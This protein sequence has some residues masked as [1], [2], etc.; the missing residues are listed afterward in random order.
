MSLR[1][2]YEDTDAGG[3]VYHSKYLNFMERA[4]SEWLRRLGFEQDVLRAGQN[5]LF[6]VRKVDIDYLK[7]AFFN[8][9][10]E[11]HSRVTDERRVS[12]VFEQIVYNRSSEMICRADVVIVCINA[13]KMKPAAIPEN[14]LTELR[15]CQP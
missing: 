12:L 15:Q 7:P 6:T 4:R 1:V 11:I 3:V 13:N 2:Y 9:L 14:I 10:L 8:E 5:L